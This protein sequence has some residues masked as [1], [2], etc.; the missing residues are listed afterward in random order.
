[1]A[2]PGSAHG[3]IWAQHGRLSDRCRAPA[4]PSV[5]TS[6]TCSWP[7]RTLPSPPPD[8]TDI[9]THAAAA[10]VKFIRRPHQPEPIAAAR[11][12]LTTRVGAAAGFACG[13]GADGGGREG[14]GGKVAFGILTGFSSCWRE[15]GPGW[16]RHIAGD[17]RQGGGMKRRRSWTAVIVGD[18]VIAA[19]AGVL[20]GWRLSQ[21][22]AALPHA[23]CGDAVTHRLDDSTHALS[24]DPGALT[25]FTAA[26]RTC[27]A[28]SIK[29][30]E[31][32]VDTGTA[33]VFSIDPGGTTCHVTELSQGYTANFGGST[34][35]VTAMS[36]RLAAVTGEGVTLDCGTQD[37]LIPS[38]VSAR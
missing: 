16:L 32:G 20:A 13:A 17:F 15:P 31:M 37:A 21:H 35:P 8:L 2:N 6:A 36:C 4:A 26:A 5:C 27:R 19:A 38:V 14:S 25:C 24:A 18:A 23:S 11:T 1:M 22:A 9:I 30:T 28:A 33:F 29:V 7:T 12:G 3:Q 10:D 34:G